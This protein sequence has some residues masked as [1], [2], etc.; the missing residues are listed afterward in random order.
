LPT[1]GED[2]DRVA[3]VKNQDLLDIARLGRI[4]TVRPDELR[5]RGLAAQHILAS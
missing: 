1:L 3:L 5:A 4:H 2:A